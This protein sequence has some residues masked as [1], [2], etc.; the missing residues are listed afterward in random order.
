MTHEVKVTI[1]DLDIKPKDQKMLQ[2]VKKELEKTVWGAGNV[3]FDE[4]E[5]EFF[6]RAILQQDL[7]I[8]YMRPTRIV[9]NV[10]GSDIDRDNLA[11]IE[12]IFKKRA[13]IEI[14]DGNL[15]LEFG[16]HAK[17]DTYTQF[18]FFKNKDEIPMTMTSKGKLWKCEI[19]GFK[20]RNREYS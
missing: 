3:H 13:S 10:S 1:K 8:F 18:G 17:D 14:R 4:G 7:H 19:H 9:I 2:K 15:V 11:L 16:F 12:N 5:M 20:W 6:E